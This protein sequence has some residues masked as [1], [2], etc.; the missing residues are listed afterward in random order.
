MSEENA[1]YLLPEYKKELGGKVK[2]NFTHWG[3]L[4]QE[5]ALIF[6][7]LNELKTE[8]SILKKTPKSTSRKK[9]TTPSSKSQTTKKSK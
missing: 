1:D 6:N 4:E 2:Y 9:A 7:S 5:I 8:V 3:Q